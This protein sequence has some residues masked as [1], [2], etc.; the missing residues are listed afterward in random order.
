[1]A[2]VQG[3]VGR[4]AAVRGARSSG[5]PGLAAVLLMV[6][7]GA[8]AQSPTITLTASPTSLAEGD[9]ATDVTV[10]TT[11]SAARTESNTV[12]LSLARTSRSAC[13]SCLKRPPG[14]W[15]LRGADRIGVD[16]ERQLANV[17]EGRAFDSHPLWLLPSP[18]CAQP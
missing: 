2:A 5:W 7:A 18:P 3:R 10:T 13:D 11:L 4:L 6:A 14:L 8:E 1:V 17:A 9:G 12:T 15:H 16:G